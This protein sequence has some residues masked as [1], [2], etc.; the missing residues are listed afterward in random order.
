MLLHQQWVVAERLRARAA[1]R[2]PEF[3]GKH[4]HKLQ[5]L[6]QDSVIGVFHNYGTEAESMVTLNELF[7]SPDAALSAFE[8][9]R[10]L[11][12]HSDSSDFFD[13]NRTGAFE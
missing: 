8:R 12:A 6:L 1:A 13:A 9:M 11:I 10:N 5:S 4:T 2:V 7:G 3:C